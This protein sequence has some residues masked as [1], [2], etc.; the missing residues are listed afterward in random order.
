MV[1]YNRD[2]D[3]RRKAYASLA[4]DRTLTFAEMSN[5][6][7]IQII[8]LNAYL[9]GWYDNNSIM[10]KHCL[11]PE[12]YIRR[13]FYQQLVTYEALKID[14]GEY[15]CPVCEK[16]TVESFPGM[17]CHTSDCP[18]KDKLYFK[19]DIN[20]LAQKIGR[21]FATFIA[22]LEEI[23][24]NFDTA[25]VDPEVLK[26]K[27]VSKALRNYYYT[28][29]LVFLNDIMC[30]RR[31]QRTRSKRTNHDDDDDDEEEE[32]QPHV[33]GRKTKRFKRSNRRKTNRRRR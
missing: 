32:E 2:R 9:P 15:E 31:A 26:D 18:N 13:V 25:N 3:N 14:N 10:L 6:T 1:K 12:Q 23:E 33:G 7:K 17:I 29:G 19:F 8:L 11:N 21:N 16:S 4:M 22:L 24:E 28:N 27:P 20:K 5:I 30:H